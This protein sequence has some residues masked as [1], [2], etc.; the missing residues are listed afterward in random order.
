MDVGGED[1]DL[2]AVVSS[3]ATER[4]RTAKGK[5][6][7]IVDSED[8]EANFDDMDD[9]DQYTDDDITD[10]SDNE[11]DPEKYG[12][13]EYEDEEEEAKKGM[14]SDDEDVEASRMKQ[15]EEHVK[16]D[17]VYVFR[18]DVR[19]RMPFP[20]SVMIRHGKSRMVPSLKRA[21]IQD[22]VKQTV[23]TDLAYLKIDEDYVHALSLVDPTGTR[24]T[25]YELNVTEEQSIVRHVI[26]TVG[27]AKKVDY[28]ALEKEQCRW[29]TKLDDIDTE[30]A[31]LPVRYAKCFNVIRVPQTKRMRAFILS[32]NFIRTRA[33]RAEKKAD[34]DTKKLSAKES[35]DEDIH[36]ITPKP[37]SKEDAPPLR[38][39][40]DRVHAPSKERTLTPN[41]A[42]LMRKIQHRTGVTSKPATTSPFSFAKKKKDP[43][44]EVVKKP[45]E[46]LPLKPSV[47][48]PAEPPPPKP[49]VN[50]PA[51]PPPPK[52]SVNK[53]AEPLPPKPSVTPNKP[54]VIP[55]E[56]GHPPNAPKRLRVDSEGAYCIIVHHLT[57][58]NLA[59][60]TKILNFE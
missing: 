15:V 43:S 16:A 52:P 11:S 18:A 44:S 25:Y 1:S 46:P 60:V 6:K 22:L 48:K 40:K 29:D 53:P 35:D 23:P 55:D 14:S 10:K 24:V 27:A 4:P 50:K 26:T 54:I 12:L 3:Y 30:S 17:T 49:S 34:K 36:D 28:A 51:E 58:A 2:D 9:E 33:E 39:T 38:I 5:R 57:P 32:T 47:K 42:A 7:P 8:E 31:A 21:H 56:P 13:D 45:A 19:T 37:P 59:A 41:N 20:S